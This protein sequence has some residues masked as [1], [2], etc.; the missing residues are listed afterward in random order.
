MNVTCGSCPAKYAVPDEKVR[1]KKA[2]IKCKHCGADILVDGTTLGASERP[3]GSPASATKA[4]GAAAPAATLPPD[5]AQ[6]LRAAAPNG[7]D[8]PH[9]QG[10]SEKPAAP[11][12][13]TAEKAAASGAGS[14]A[15]EKADSG[16]AANLGS[17]QSPPPGTL[18]S[19]R[20][21]PIAKIQ[22]KTVSV[23]RSMST[24]QRPSDAAPQVTN[25]PAPAP[26]AVA[27]AASASALGSAVATGPAQPTAAKPA[28][29]PIHKMT[30]VG[31]AGPAPGS[32]SPDV[33]KANAP[34]LN[35]ASAPP[36][37]PEG[38]KGK[39]AIGLAA[40][41]GAN[42][43]LLGGAQAPKF[44]P[45]PITSPIR[46]EPPLVGPDPSAKA[47]ATQVWTVAF[48]DGTQR[49]ASVTD[50]QDLFA[51]GKI[52]DENLVWQEGMTDWVALRNLPALRKSLMGR[53]S[54]RPPPESEPVT[55][56]R[57]A[58]G[59]PPNK[60]DAKAEL[61][62][63]S[64]PLTTPQNAGAHEG[65]WKEPG[66]WTAGSDRPTSQHPQTR[67]DEEISMALGSSIA[68]SEMIDSDAPRPP[69][70]TAPTRPSPLPQSANSASAA[71]PTP[72]GDLAPSTPQ[73]SSTA[74]AS[75]ASP[76]DSPVPKRSTSAAR[77]SLAPA[78]EV[79]TERRSSK[80]PMVLG[81]LV[82]AAIGA[83]VVIYKTQTPPG[84]FTFLDQ[85]L[86]MPIRE[87]LGGGAPPA[88]V[89]PPAP[90][91]TPTSAPPEPAQAAIPP[92]SPTEPPSSATGSA[93]AQAAATAPTAPATPAK[94]AG[95]VP[96]QAD[97]VDASKEKAAAE[98]DEA[99]A[100][101]ELARLSNGIQ[102]CR[103]AEPPGKGQVRVTFGP[104][105]ETTAASIAGQYAASDAGLCVID[106]FRQAKVRPF[107]GE[108]VTV[109]HDF[110]LQ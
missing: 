7:L 40:V 61:E 96:T 75:T 66:S 59:E 101:S 27:G 22:P 4:A 65:V 98:F 10:V 69:S 48:L 34:S 20:A 41:R 54:T 28:A 12:D 46:Q 74:G 102:K 32:H 63:A 94:E 36:A 71:V 53:A 58:G 47:P 11:P 108:S 43:T 78:P 16:S 30:M 93:T 9:G 67:L 81:L 31:L 33:A 73:K 109:S 104:S 92:S 1:G 42:Q 52:S 55:Q 51:S 80:L 15:H 6:S 56:N 13:A 77:A 2:R 44:E 100:Q 29:K 85:T 95:E 62:P 26:S 79:P 88:P 8:Q 64:E 50:L 105:G 39:P 89:A 35:V 90:E 24:D 87:A 49:E 107:S 83:V 5:A 110:A 103:G 3:S 21:T 17:R 14:N 97:K 76:S 38:P 72:A 25:K 45:P 99:K 106:I 57:F 19:P 18:T 84:A 37:S 91:A 82:T 60:G 23:P 68:E 70:Q 86:P